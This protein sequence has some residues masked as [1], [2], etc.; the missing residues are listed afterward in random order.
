M[1]FLSNFLDR[2]ERQICILNSNLNMILFCL[3][4]KQHF[5]FNIRAADRPTDRELVSKANRPFSLFAFGRILIHSWPWAGPGLRST[6][7]L[8]RHTAE[9]SSCASRP[10]IW[11]WS[12]PSWTCIKSM[13]TRSPGS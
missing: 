4:D 10:W 11:K 7:L 5:Y 13:N 6:T 8:D 12:C 9:L 2:W 1:I 3:K